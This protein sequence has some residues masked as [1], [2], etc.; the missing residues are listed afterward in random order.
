MQALTMV[1]RSAEIIK[2][3]KAGQDHSPAIL[4]GPFGKC[5]LLRIIFLFKVFM[6]LLR[7]LRFHVIL[8][9]NVNLPSENPQMTLYPLLQV[10][11]FWPN[12]NRSNLPLAKRYIWKKCELM[13]VVECR[14]R[15]VAGY[16]TRI[17]FFVFRF[18]K[19]ERQVREAGH[20]PNLSGNRTIIS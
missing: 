3:M 12:S 10:R 13:V 4:Y 6:L 1:G 18:L 5:E 2:S 20:A 19:G 8:D 11:M 9:W 15:N 14:I 16:I 7:T 17:P